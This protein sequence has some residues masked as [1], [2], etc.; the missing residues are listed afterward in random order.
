MFT[1]KEIQCHQGM[2]SAPNCTSNS[3]EKM[4]VMVT[5]EVF[6]IVTTK[7]NKKD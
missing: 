1:T 2:S 4:G 3:N 6:Y 7:K 5:G